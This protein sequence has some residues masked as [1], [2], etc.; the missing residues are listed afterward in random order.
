MSCRLVSFDN[1]KC[2]PNTYS[3]LQLV[4]CSDGDQLLFPVICWLAAPLLAFDARCNRSFE[5]GETGVNAQRRIFSKHM[6]TLVTST[7]LASRQDDSTIMRAK[8]SIMPAFS[9]EHLPRLTCWSGFT[10]P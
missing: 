10:E 9:I 2:K 7:A 4:V 6:P 3:R 8:I 1:G 5:K